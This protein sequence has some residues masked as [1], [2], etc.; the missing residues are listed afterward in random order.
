[1]SES[2]GK[3]KTAKRNRGYGNGTIYYRASDQRWVGKFTKGRKPDGKPDLIVV[4]GKTE[5]EAQKKLNKKIDEFRKNT[6][7]A[8]VEKRTV[9]DYLQDWLKNVK[10]LQ[11]K[12]KSYDR[13]EQTIERDVVPYIGHIQIG[14]LTAMDVQGML[15]KMFEGGR[16]YSSIEKAYDAVNAAYKY[17]LVVRPPIVDYNPCTAVELPNKKNF[18]RPDIKFYTKDEAA[19]LCAAALKKY[20]NGRQIYRLGAAIVLD[21]NTGLRIGELAG[22]RWKDV[23]FENN[24][25]HVNNTVV[26]V[27]N[28]NQKS[29]NDKKFITKEQDSAKTDAGEGRPIPLNSDALGALKNLQ[30]VTGNFDHVLSSKDGVPTS[31]RDIDKLMR[32]V[33]R[34]AGFTEEKTYGIHALRHTFATLLLSNGVDIKVVSE[35]LGHSSTSITYNTYIH[36]IKE[37]KAKAIASLPNL[38]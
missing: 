11:L 38:T 1:M 8:Y 30:A 7:Y 16:S 28:R 21:V 6:N 10:R 4:Y 13:L 25:I 23:D 20:G 17:G 19:K 35:L 2:S 32:N 29:D 12:E 9:E 24:I 27:R 37:Q 34:V 33:C 3:T 18:K 26:R 5:A 15:T 22:L 36:V 31:I 14:S